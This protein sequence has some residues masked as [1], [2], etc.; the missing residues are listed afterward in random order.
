MQ[1]IFPVSLNNELPHIAIIHILVGTFKFI[2]KYLKYFVCV[3]T[4]L[5]VALD[6]VLRMELLSLQYITPI[7]YSYIHIL[8]SHP[9]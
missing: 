6:A 9:D 8:L 3:K 2:V 5:D 7:R 1:Y 4:W